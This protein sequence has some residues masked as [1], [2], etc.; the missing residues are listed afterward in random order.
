MGFLAAIPLLGQALDSIF[1]GLDKLF[2]S[3]DERLK[4]Q[5]A[6]LMAIMPVVTVLIQAQAEFDRQRADLERDAMKSEDWFVRR[7]RPAMSWVTFVWWMSMELMHSARADYAFYAF[8]IVS[9]IWS[10]TRGIEK[11]IPVWTNGKTGNGK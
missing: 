9:G 8:C 4:G 10:A 3:D 2:T 5:H 11:I 1:S 7:S 6:I